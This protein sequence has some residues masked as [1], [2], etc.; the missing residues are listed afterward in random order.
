MTI[1]LLIPKHWVPKVIIWDHD[2]THW[3]CHVL[4]FDVPN[5]DYSKNDEKQII[6]TNFPYC[7]VIRSI[8]D[9][10]F[11]LCANLLW[12]NGCPYIF[13]WRIPHNMCQNIWRNF[14][15]FKICTHVIHIP[16]N[17]PSYFSLTCNL[18]VVNSIYIYIIIYYPCFCHIYTY[19][20]YKFI[21]YTRYYSIFLNIYT[22]IQYSML[23]HVISY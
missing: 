12:F 2:E 10:C 5:F 19:I 20:H 22:Y 16:H 9:I 23:Y 6:M 3:P 14:H 15:M 17:C 11:F 18:H 13:N 1:W 7:F 21:L 4:A 8:F